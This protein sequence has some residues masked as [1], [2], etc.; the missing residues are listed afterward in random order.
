MF[1]LDPWSVRLFDSESSRWISNRVVQR[2]Y[3]HNVSTHGKC[4]EIKMSLQEKSVCVHIFRHFHLNRMKTLK[5]LNPTFWYFSQNVSF[6][7]PIVW[8]YENNRRASHISVYL[9]QTPHKNRWPIAIS[10]KCVF[11]TLTNFNKVSIA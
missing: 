3:C 8:V 6:G 11:T 5:S 1:S 10:T 9:D 2:S 4:A 7:I